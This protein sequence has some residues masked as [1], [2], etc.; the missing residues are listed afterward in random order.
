MLACAC[1]FSSVD[2]M[3]TT[4]APLRG[5]ARTSTTTPPLTH[6][7]HNYYDLHASDKTHA[8][9]ACSADLMF[10]CVFGPRFVESFIIYDSLAFARASSASS[11]STS[12]S[13]PSSCALAFR[14]NP[15]SNRARVWS[16]R[17]VRVSLA[18]VYYLFSGSG[19]GGAIA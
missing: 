10:V 11:A 15:E 16:C 2:K 14:S 9:H 4:D 12:A 18:C 6:T 3:S 1:V 8:R 5:C 7:T 17:G 19:S 13:P